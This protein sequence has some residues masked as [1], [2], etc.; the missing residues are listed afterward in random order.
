MN[1]IKSETL[2][3]GIMEFV[4]SNVIQSIYDTFLKK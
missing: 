4:N 1:R 2:V 3:D